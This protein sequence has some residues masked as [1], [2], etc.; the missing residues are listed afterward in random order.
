LE[1]LRIENRQWIDSQRSEAETAIEVIRDSALKR[2]KVEEHHGGLVILTAVYGVLPSTPEDFLQNEISEKANLAD[3]TV[4]L[5][6]LVI[7]GSLIIPGGR[8]KS[9]LM[10]FYDCAF[11]EEKQ[12][13]I[14]YLFGRKEHVVKLKDTESL[15]IPRKCK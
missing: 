14:K 12:L 11:G 9:T 10:G 7:N 8:S 2:Q 1:K 15:T 13:W 6:N 3:V 5:Q 4:A